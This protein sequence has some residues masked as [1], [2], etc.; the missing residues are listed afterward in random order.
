MNAAADI[1]KV[2]AARNCALH[3]RRHAIANGEHA[4]L[5]EIAAHFF[6]RRKAGFIDRCVRFAGNTD[7]AAKLFVICCHGAGAGNDALAALYHQIGV[8]AD[9]RRLAGDEAFQHFRIVFRRFRLVIEETGADDGFR[10]HLADPFD[11][12]TFQQRH[13]PLGAEQK[14]FSWAF[15]DQAPGDVSR[16]DDAVIGLIRHAENAKLGDDTGGRTRRIGDEHHGLA[17]LARVVQRNRRIRESANAIMQHAPDIRKNNVEPI[18]D[19]AESENAVGH[20]MLSGCEKR[21]CVT[22]QS[23][24]PMARKK[25]VSDRSSAPPDAA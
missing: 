24:T 10:F 12:E 16:C 23:G 15:R 7:F 21:V 3:I 5:R 22:S 11:I 20:E 6:R 19:F 4:I 2:E 17:G 9:H 25:A 18:S 14:D 13:V 8:G 1:K